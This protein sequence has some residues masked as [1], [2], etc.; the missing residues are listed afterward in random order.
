MRMDWGLMEDKVLV[1]KINMFMEFQYLEFG[2]GE[3]SIGVP[4]DDLATVLPATCYEHGYNKIHF[5]GNENYI[6]GLIQNIRAE[7]TRV[8]SE[9][10]LKFEVN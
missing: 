3:P 1:C 5:F 7:E 9:N 2:D 8:Y 4:F 6:S 10:K